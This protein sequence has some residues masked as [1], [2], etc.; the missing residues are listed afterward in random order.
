[1]LKNKIMLITGA[2]QGLGRTIALNAA[3]YGATIIFT[4]SKNKEKAQSTL[5]ELNNISSNKHM[6]FQV[7]CFDLE[8]NINMYSQ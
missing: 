5:E 4:F 6:S 2:T 8:E 1:M 3:K 7:N